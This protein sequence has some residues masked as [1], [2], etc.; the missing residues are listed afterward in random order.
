VTVAARLRLTPA[1]AP[2]LA[3]VW[4]F[5]AIALPSLAALLAPMPAVDLAYQIRAGGEIL[6]SGSIPSLDSWTFTIAG[7]PWT[8]QQWGAQLLLAAVYRATGWSGMVLL[9]AVLVG[10]SFGLLLLLVRRRDPQLDRRIATLLVLA[11]FLVIA[12]ALALRP[13]LFAIPLFVLTL[14]ILA[15][16]VRH[17]RLI[18]AIP[19][20]AL[21]WAN[22]HGSFPLVVVL[23]GLA[24]IADV[25]DGRGAVPVGVVALA[26]VAAT[27]V[28]PFGP[29]VWAYVVR[30][31]TNPTIGSR[32]SEWRPPGLTDVPGFLFWLS[33]GAVAVGL[34]IRADRRRRATPR[35][36]E[37]GHPPFP[38][39]RLLPGRM[40][41]LTLIAFAAL[42]AVTGRGLAWWPPAALFVVV[43]LIRERRHPDGHI[44]D[45]QIEWADAQAASLGRRSPLNTAVLAVLLVAGIALL[46]M[47]RPTGPAGVPLA[48]LSYAPQGIGAY[49]AVQS[50]DLSK[51][52]THPPEFGRV[53]APQ[54]WASWFEL[55][56]PLLTY[57]VDSRI[58]LFPTSIWAD[59]DTVASGT[60]GTG[61]AGSW[62]AVL[63]RY[64]VRLVVTE[65]AADARLEAALQA[66]RAWG[67]VY[68][69]ADGSVW[70]RFGG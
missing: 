17:P 7:T 42:G 8:D 27:F 53:W 34:A 16:R 46:P 58:E 64:A 25:M 63:D 4:T 3:T 69:D 50:A 36:N 6:D 43:P 66:S 9:R 51:V 59:Y 12:P 48:I 33:V 56:G 68:T 60:D 26:S 62:S 22:L 54:H 70:A 47:W 35:P 39:L 44:T 61:G 2:T 49:L 13:Q 37:P 29:A 30:L 20:I 23:L 57:E 45:P 28:T 40:A 11:A 5:L 24:L 41:M 15:I 21:A 65:A 38:P 14:L 10:L 19:V 31:A 1:A 55:Q 52:R 32:V 67:R 18:W